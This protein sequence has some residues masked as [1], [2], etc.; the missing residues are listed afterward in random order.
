MVEEVGCCS[1][2]LRKLL[3]KSGERSVGYKFCRDLGQG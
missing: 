2:K 3:V 1:M